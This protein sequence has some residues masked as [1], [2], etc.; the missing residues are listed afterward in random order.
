MQVGQTVLGDDC[1][2]CKPF[3]VTAAS[4]KSG[5]QQKCP[6]DSVRKQ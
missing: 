2:T 5:F 3:L 1:V 6:T 4:E